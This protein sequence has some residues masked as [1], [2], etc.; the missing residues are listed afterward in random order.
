MSDGGSKLLAR[1]GG[2]LGR[3]GLGAA[4]PLEMLDELRSLRRRHVA[5]ARLIAAFEAARAAGCDF[6]L[7][8]CAGCEYAPPRLRRR[9]A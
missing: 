3:R 4:S 6:S 7:V 2:L 5:V 1:A 8:G 9:A